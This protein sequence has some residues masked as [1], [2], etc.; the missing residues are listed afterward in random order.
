MIIGGIVGVICVKLENIGFFAIGFALAY[1][2]SNII[3]LP[4]LSRINFDYP[5][6]SRV[7]CMVLTSY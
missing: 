4:I 6:V 3:Y 2:I 5:E 7:F 1:V